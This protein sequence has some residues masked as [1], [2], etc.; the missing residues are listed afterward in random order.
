MFRA[1]VTTACLL[2]VGDEILEGHT[3]DTNSHYL[4][5]RLEA[6]GIQLRH[7]VTVRDDVD[8]IGG[9][10]DHLLSDAPDVVLVTGG[11]GPTPDDRTYEGVAIALGVPLT[12]NPADEAWLKASVARTTYGLGLLEDEAQREGLLRM[13]R[14][15]EGSA[16]VDNPVGMALGSAARSGSATVFVLPGVPR[17]LQAMME[18][19]VEPNYLHAKKNGHARAELELR[20]EEARL[21]TVLRDAEMRHPQVRIGSYPQDEPGRILLRIQGP[22]AEVERVAEALA[23]ATGARRTR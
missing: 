18:R 16:A 20:G 12:I 7:I 14:R 3:Q 15:P 19:V 17:E 1:G 4:A 21:Y 5:R 2:V 22:A 10:L 6:L 23:A 13:I 11:I 9:A 8:E